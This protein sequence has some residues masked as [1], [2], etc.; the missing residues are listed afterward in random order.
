ML[1]D[2]LTLLVNQSCNL[3]DAAVGRESKPIR[4]KSRK[5]NEHRRDLVAQRKAGPLRRADADLQRRGVGD[6][7]FVSSATRASAAAKLERAQHITK[8]CDGP[9]P[10]VPPYRSAQRC[11]K[12]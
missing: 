11:A 9:D 10:R 12:T 2:T 3:E 6:W 7:G 5:R 1:T 4:S 8:G